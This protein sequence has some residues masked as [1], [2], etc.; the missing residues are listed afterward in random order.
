MI[1]ETFVITIL[2]NVQNKMFGIMVKGFIQ[3]TYTNTRFG[4]NILYSSEVI[5]LF[6]KN[7][8]V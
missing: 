8:K 6:R 3:N 5:N 1:F 7:T 2:E 4:F